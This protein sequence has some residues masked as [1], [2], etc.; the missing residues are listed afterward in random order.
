[1][2]RKGIKHTKKGGE[3]REA[4][5]LTEEEVV[6]E[7]AP[8]TYDPPTSPVVQYQSEEDKWNTALVVYY[9][10]DGSV[11]LNVFSAD[12]FGSE[13]KTYVKP[14]EEVGQWREFTVP[15]LTPPEEPEGPEE[16][17]AEP[18]EE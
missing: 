11:S 2:R 7:E 14:G 8:K 9:N 16:P 13:H 17:E 1:M 12:G 4:V 3:E 15:D 6:D 10:P 18:R 5:G